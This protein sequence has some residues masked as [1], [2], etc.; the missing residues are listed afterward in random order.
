[1]PGEAADQ[2]Q[3]YPPCDENCDKECFTASL[4]N[5]NPA[6][7]MA[8]P[9]SGQ[10]SGKGSARSPRCHSERNG[11]NRSCP[12]ASK[13][14]ESPQPSFI[15]SEVVVSGVDGVILS[16]E[17]SLSGLNNE[18]S[19]VPQGLIAGSA[20]SRGSAAW[21]SVCDGNLITR[22]ELEEIRKEMVV[23]ERVIKALGEDNMKLH[24]ERKDLL[25]TVNEL[26]GVFD[27][28]A[29]RGVVMDSHPT[30]SN[31]KRISHA[32]TTVGLGQ[33][34]TDV[35]E[36]QLEIE[37]LREEKRNLENRLAVLDTRH[38]Y[39]LESEV[40]NLRLDLKQK[41]VEHS[42]MV[43]EMS[44]KIAWYVD[45]Q[46][47]NHSQ[48]E[49]LKE[50]ERTIHHLRA[51]LNERKNASDGS[52]STQRGKD[53]QISRLM[54]RI[55]ELEEALGT[56][57][58]NSIGQLIRSCQPSAEESKLFKQLNRRIKE[59][60]EALVEKDRCADAAVTRL[61][62]ETDR[63]NKQY[64]EQIEKLE[65]QLKTKLLHAQSRRVRD[66]EKQLAEAQRALDEK[67]RGGP[68]VVSEGA[69][70]PSCCA[71][72]GKAPGS[73]ASG[74]RDPS[75]GEA[76]EPLRKGNELLKQHF[77]QEHQI[78]NTSGSAPVAPPDAFAASCTDRLISYMQTQI[79]N[80]TS[81]LAATR[82][83][84]EE[85]QQSIG[86]MHV[87]W[88]DR[89]LAV[90]KDYQAQLQCV[91]QRHDEDIARIRDHHQELKSL[92]ERQ[93]NDRNLCVFKKV[94]KLTSK[95]PRVRE[96]LLSVVERLSY[97]ERCQIQRDREVELEMM[98]IKR[99]ADF[100]IA[101][102]RQKAEIL[103][104]EKNQQI[105]GFQAQLD[106]LL[107]TVALLKGDH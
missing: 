46:E 65:E 52:K 32:T 93:E 4:E 76:V 92:V 23:Q 82:R 72:L 95:G 8:P 103:L 71:V 11:D 89:L 51:E 77:L 106:Q 30:G 53:A 47:F 14:L 54:K 2:L 27:A 78:L 60:E 67:D 101:L 96:F 85:N 74:A 63:M 48:E 29:C 59:L 79:T 42:E 66:L 73:V 5:K 69:E 58:P 34:P 86:N 84:L 18:S 26:K 6:D 57:R 25:A 17:I 19:Q 9:Q 36:L 22:E 56:N 100:E 7:L 98:K 40:R 37:I 70:P 13:G 38:I 105:R 50:Q 28:R 20:S 81:E 88:D 44:R 1:M 43:R 61:R 3:L 15:R 62:V 75:L 12:V 45:N 68:Q 21:R 33:H 90:K 41:E 35:S 16:P 55:A 99:V 87:Q 39:E 102:E 64:Q 83:S 94:D 104:E 80:M 107:A 91:Q 24:K 49:L 31:N 10:E 97:L